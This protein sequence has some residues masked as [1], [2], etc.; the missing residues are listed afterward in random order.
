VERTGIKECP[1]FLSSNLYFMNNA[2]HVYILDFP[3][4]N[5]FGGTIL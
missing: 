3:R 5:N 1:Q 4:L 2:C